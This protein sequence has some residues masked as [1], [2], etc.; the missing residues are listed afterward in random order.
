MIT[1]RSI[2]RLF[3]EVAANNLSKAA[4]KV[5]KD[6]TWVDITWGEAD[7]RV[8]QI[9]RALMALGVTK[10][11]R[12]S[13]LGNSSLDWQL[14][15]FGI[16]N[17]GGVTVG[18]YQSNL[19]PDCAYILNHCEAQILFVENDHQLQKI[20]PLRDQVK[21]LRQIVTFDGASDPDNDVLSLEDF[22]AR[23]DDVPDNELDEREASL[24]YVMGGAILA[25]RASPTFL[26]KAAPGSAP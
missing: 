10:G 9:S 11:E 19:G 22:E 18:I 16:V 20:V 14:T 3:H 21:H 5:R 23:A 13:I 7:K 25:L 2:P 8:R 26:P 24:L 17:A 15:D 12:V 1:H 4:Y 6:G